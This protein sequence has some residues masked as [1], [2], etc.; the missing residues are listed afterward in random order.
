MAIPSKTDLVTL[1][2]SYQGMPFCRV[3]AQAA[4]DTQN[5]DTSYLAQPFVAAGEGNQVIVEEIAESVDTVA[6]TLARAWVGARGPSES[7]TTVSDSVVAVVARDRAVSESVDT[8][9]DTVARA[10]VGARGPAE[11]VDTVSDTVDI[12]FSVMT[13]FV[14]E[15]VTTVSDSV[16]R[17]WNGQRASAERPPS[18][19][20]I[21]RSGN[22]VRGG[23]A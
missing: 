6:D 7:V 13:R 19:P 9:S 15:S 18:G 14:A 11:S 4:F 17:A 12:N 1:D 8:V 2:Y 20:V 10:W 21:G 5:L 16:A 22:L 23:L 3:A